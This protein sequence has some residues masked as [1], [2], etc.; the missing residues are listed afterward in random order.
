MKKFD[1]DVIIV[2]AGI[3]G[4]SCAKTLMKAG[5]KF[6][7]LEAGQKLASYKNISH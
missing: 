5:I 4:L 7:I 1:T 6:L 3:S 2:G